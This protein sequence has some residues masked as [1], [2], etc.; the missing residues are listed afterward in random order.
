MRASV[1]A[2]AYIRDTWPISG[3]LEDVLQSLQQMSRTSEISF[4]CLCSHPRNIIGIQLDKNDVRLR[5]GTRPASLPGSSAVAG[6]NIH[7][8]SSMPGIFF[9]RVRDIQGRKRILGFQS[10]VQLLA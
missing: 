3:K 10:A 2:Q 7:D 6:C 5:C 1:C 9:F 8:M 4:H